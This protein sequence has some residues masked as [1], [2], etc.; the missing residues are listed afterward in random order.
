MSKRSPVSL[1][2]KLHTVQRCLDHQTNP[3]A[4]AKHMGVS[5]STVGSWIRK[6]KADGLDGL[7]ES[8]PG[9][10]TRRN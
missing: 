7:T 9:K 5:P 3:H 2:L 8:K 1:E 4:E 6:Y 10:H